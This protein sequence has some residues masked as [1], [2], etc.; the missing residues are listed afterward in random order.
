MNNEIDR[1]AIQQRIEALRKKIETQGI[2]KVLEKREITT[3][4][5]HET[6]SLGKE[7]IFY[8]IEGRSLL[9]AIIACLII[10]IGAYFLNLKTDYLNIA[11]N[12][13]FRLFS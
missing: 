12:Y 5:K 7:G 6:I 11:S 9:I 13:F 4:P 2:A 1:K 8:L 3:N 10:I